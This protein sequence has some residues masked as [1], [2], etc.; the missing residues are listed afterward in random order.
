MSMDSEWIIAS[1]TSCKV[2]VF[3]AKT[4]A[5]VKNLSGHTQGV[6][7]LHLVS[8][9]GTMGGPPPMGTNSTDDWDESEDEDGV[10]MDY[11]VGS[12][13]ASSPYVTAPSSSYDAGPSTSSSNSS[14]LWSAVTP[15]S[16]STSAATSAY[17]T[18]N[19][20]PTPQP[21]AALQPYL[22]LGFGGFAGFQGLAAGFGFGSTSSSLNSSAV[23]TPII[24]PTN[25]L[26]PHPPGFP[27]PPVNTGTTPPRLTCSME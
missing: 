10:G 22:G 17:T 12:R 4:G 8:K 13:R 18:A 5:H 21:N 19:S 23:G 1:L 6:W 11:G 3:S 9:G 14:S 16:M 27:F 20:T 26:H 24:A 15:S 7:A 25:T 2:L